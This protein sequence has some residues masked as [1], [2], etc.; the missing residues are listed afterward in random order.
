MK[1][2]RLSYSYEDYDSGKKGPGTVVADLLKN[3][4]FPQAESIEIGSW[5]SPWEEGCQALLDAIAAN[6]GEFSHV[7][8]L[9]IGIMDYEDC[10]MSW[11]IQGDYS[12]LWSALPNLKSLTIQGSVELSLGNI[13]HKG[14]EELTIICGGLPASQI[15]QI[16]KAKLPSLKKLVLYLGV[17]QY[18]F[19]GAIQDIQTLL[20]ESDF[21]SLEYL[22]I[23]NS[24]IQNK[25]AGAVLES[26]YMNQIHTLDLSCGSLTDEGGALLLEKL[27]SF[28]QIATLDLHFHYL[29]DAMMKQLER[30]P[31]SVDVSDQQKSEKWEDEEWYD[32]MITE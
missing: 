31:L 9:A 18:G 11:I 17:E 13:H 1:E 8:K 6:A 7:R 15:H 27:P 26:K 2:L 30:L 21:P 20:S 19:D 12:K 16:T 14:L 24:N 28:P 10:E 29:S 4:A 23:V 22:G 32:P 5:G 3:P 25:V